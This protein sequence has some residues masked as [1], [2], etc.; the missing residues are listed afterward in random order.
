VLFEVPVGAAPLLKPP[1]IVL[2]LLE[3]GAA[4]LLKPP[5]IVLPL[6]KP[7]LAGLDSP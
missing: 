6:L 1:Q 2:R 3:L 7:P 4:P 5:E